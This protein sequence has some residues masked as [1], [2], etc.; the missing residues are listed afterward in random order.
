MVQRAG[1]AALRHHGQESA[2][3][4]APPDVAAVEIL[5]PRKKIKIELDWPTP[6]PYVEP[7][8]QVCALCERSK[9]NWEF[10]MGSHR[11][12]AAHPAICYDCRHGMWSKRWLNN[13]SFEDHTF[14]VDTDAVIRALSAE[15]KHAR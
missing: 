13:L 15:C 14:I 10:R 7:P 3:G 2:G 11:Y 8:P 12:G 4:N 1:N 6:K 5:P 9:P